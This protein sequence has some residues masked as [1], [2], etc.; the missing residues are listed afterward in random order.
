MII[1]TGA[2]AYD[3]GCSQFYLVLFFGC[4][5]LEAFYNI[6]ILNDRVMVKPTPAAI[7]PTAVAGKIVMACG[8][9]VCLI[10]SVIDLF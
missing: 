1:D 3:G 4:Q 8:P 6:G 2:F 7:I 5:R 9:V 10:H